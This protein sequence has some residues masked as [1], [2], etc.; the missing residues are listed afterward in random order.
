MISMRVKPALEEYAFAEMTRERVQSAGIKMYRPIKKVE[1]P[2]PGSSR[3]SA[4]G[5][6]YDNQQQSVLR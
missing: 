1:V 6:G 2:K 5:P 3:V 4:P